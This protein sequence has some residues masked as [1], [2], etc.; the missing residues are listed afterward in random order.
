[1]L[2]IHL[3]IVVSY[4]LLEIILL[5]EDT[6]IISR[7]DYNTLLEIKIRIKDI[8]E[9]KDK[10]KIGLIKELDTYFIIKNITAGGAADLL[11]LTYFFYFFEEEVLSNFDIIKS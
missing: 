7:S 10:N 5:I 2:V 11:S 8:L 6:N 4:T 1:M 3:M 9:L